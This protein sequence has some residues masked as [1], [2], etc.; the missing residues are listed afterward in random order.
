[1][2]T[3]LK[4]KWAICLSILTILVLPSC[5]PEGEND[6]PF[7]PDFDL[8][9]SVQMFIDDNYPGF[10]QTDHGLEDFCDDQPAIEVELEDG[11]GPDVDLY[12]DPDGNFL[13]SA[14]DVVLAD[15]PAEVL[16]AIAATYPDYEIEEDDIELQ[17]WADG[18]IRY[19]V[20]IESTDDDLELVLNADGSIYCIDSDEDDDD[21]SDD[22]GDDDGDHDDDD[23][24]V[25]IPEEVLTLIE[26]NYPGYMS[27]E[28]DTEDICD[29]FNVYEVELED[30]PGTDLYLYFDLDWNFLFTAEE[31][32]ADDL[33]STVLDV[34][35]S[36]YP[37]YEIEDDDIDRWT[38]ADGST[39]YALELEDGDDDLDIVF[40]E[41]G[42]IYCIEMD[43][44]DEDDDEDD[45][46]EDEDDEDDDE[47]DDDEDDDD[48]D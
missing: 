4:T 45:D 16:D 48:D 12:F 46:D 24:D 34:I 32:S 38:W 5:L 7:T 29:N 22:D 1:M 37:D 15:L 18:S 33:P 13:F 11:P 41:D 3:P 42:S 43:E 17:E 21:D 25:N 39:S 10:D 6:G 40:N 2:Y 36:D 31:V 35:A 14:I 19:E 27:I 44:D 30:G 26:S 9:A 8:P 47:D 20:G 28:A 23:E